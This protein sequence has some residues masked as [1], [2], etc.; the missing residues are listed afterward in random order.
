MR[1]ASSPAAA[2]RCT[3]ATAWRCCARAPHTSRPPA[4]ASRPLTLNPSK[5]LT[6]RGFLRKNLRYQVLSPAAAQVGSNLPYAA[7]HQYGRDNIPPRP[8][9]GPSRADRS[10]ILEIIADW[11]AELGFK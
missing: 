7:T 3:G 2:P 8:Y 5:T 9:L 10:E 1:N 4:S 11:A 6:E